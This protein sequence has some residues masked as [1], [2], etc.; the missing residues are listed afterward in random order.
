MNRSAAALGALAAGIAVGA[1]LRGADNALLH[2]LADLVRPLGT[3]W[4]NALKMTLVPLVFAMVA[5]GI[6]ALD[7]GRGGGQLLAI[8]VPL[9][10][11][12]LAFAMLAGMA[13][14]LAFEAA[15]PASRVTLGVA[16]ASAAVPEVPSIDAML[17]GLLPAN[18]VA[19]ASDGAMASLVVFAI[20]FGFAVSRTTD[21]SGDAITPFVEQL[22]TA[23]LRIVHWVLLFAPVGIFALALGL[24]LDNGLEIAGFVARIVLVYGVCAALAILLGYLVAW[25]G[26]GFEPGRFGRAIAGCQAMAAGTCS[27]AATLPLMIETSQAK[28][29]IPP[30]IGGSVLPLAV[31]IFRFGVPLC[32]GAIVI[33]FM[34]SIGLSLDPA[35]LLLGGAVLILSNMGAAGLPGAAV[36]YASWAAGLQVLGLPFELI[37]LLIAAN[38]LPDIILTAANVTGHLAVTSVVSRRLSGGGVKTSAAVPEPAA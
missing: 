11:G 38:A 18:P 19:A 21:R 5:K 13:I 28:L 12:L 34:R 30:A 16:G 14:G 24:A 35:T 29:G 2:G 37:P 6:I 4:L 36:M 33:L 15:W 1:A 7:R 31:A 25:I 17:I 3:L 10:V 20:I 8:A 32:Q 23:M 22:A 27:S 9:M 26:G